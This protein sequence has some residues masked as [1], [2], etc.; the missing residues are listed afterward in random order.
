[1]TLS[2][3]VVDS[4]LGQQADSPAAAN[5]NRVN[6]TFHL[7]SVELPDGFSGYMGANWIDAWAGMINSSDG[8]IKIGWQAGLIEYVGVTRAKEIVWRRDDTS[9]EF[10]IHWMRLRNKHGDTLVAKIGWLEFSSDLSSK[11]D[12]D[13]FISIVRSFNKGRCSTCR[14]LPQ[15][16]KR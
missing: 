4:V 14:T 1:M 2:F 16:I 6:L 9:Q 11:E 7:G 12:E 8:K 15:K 5:K 13:T 10:P 3:V